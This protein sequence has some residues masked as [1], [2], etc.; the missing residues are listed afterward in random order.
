MRRRRFA[1]L[2]GISPFSKCIWGEMAKNNDTYGITDEQL[3]LDELAQA[4]ENEKEKE[5]YDNLDKKHSVGSN[6]KKN[7]SSSIMIDPSVFKQIKEEE[8]KNGTR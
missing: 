8:N 6:I 3:L 1:K 7:S 2:Y 5:Y 4:Y